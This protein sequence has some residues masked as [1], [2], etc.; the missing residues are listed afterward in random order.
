MRER[1][2]EKIGNEGGRQ[3]AIDTHTK[4]LMYWT[5]A[6]FILYIF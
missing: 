6:I 4:E 5:G 1:R 3:S 2:R